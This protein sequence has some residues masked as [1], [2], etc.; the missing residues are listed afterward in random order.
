MDD[1]AP[2]KTALDADIAPIAKPKEPFVED[3]R[4]DLGHGFNEKG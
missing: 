4:A 1:I 2:E 3:G